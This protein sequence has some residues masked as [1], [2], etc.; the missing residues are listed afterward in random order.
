[1][2]VLELI[3]TVGIHASNVGVPVLLEVLE[4]EGMRDGPEPLDARRV[5]PSRPSFIDEP[6]LLAFVVGRAAGTGSGTVRGLCRVLV[7]AV[8]D[9]RAGT[10]RSR[11]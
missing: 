11:S 1:M 6:R 7:G 5:K 10:R 2:E 4:E 3:S 8:A 9:R